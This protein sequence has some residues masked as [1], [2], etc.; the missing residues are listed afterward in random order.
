MIYIGNIDAA[1]LMTGFAEIARS[2]NKEIGTPDQFYYH[3]L[4][5]PTK[6][7][8]QVDYFESNEYSLDDQNDDVMILKRIHQYE[9]CNK[10]FIEKEYCLIFKK[11][12]IIFYNDFDE[13][14]NRE[15]HAV[16]NAVQEY[17]DGK[18]NGGWL[19]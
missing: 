8:E 3:Y 18:T 15:K 2:L 16:I 19:A 9:Y 10:P 13:R 1:N 14:Y 17:L 6:L 12:G 4:F 7:K 5:E 11:L